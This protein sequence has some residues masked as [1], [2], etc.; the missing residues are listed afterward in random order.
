MATKRSATSADVEALKQALANT[1]AT[2]IGPSDEGFS[3]TIARWSKAAEKPA[4]VSVEPT[5]SEQVSIA[6]KY[7]TDNNLDLA[8]MG[9]GHSTAG[10]SSTDGGVLINLGRMRNVKVDVGEKQFHVEG[11]ALWSDVDAAGWEHGLATVGG[12]VAD[13]GVGGLT[14]GGGYGH[15]TGK[16]GLVID[17]VISITTVLAD[18]TI[19]KSSKDRHPEL[20]WGLLGAGQ[21][22]GVSTEFVFQAFPQDELWVG[23]MVFPAVP[24]IVKGLVN[25]LNELYQV[26][27]TPNGPEAKAKGRCGSLLALAKPPPAGGQ[28]MILLL[29]AFNGTEAEGK[30]VFKPFLDLGPVENTMAMQPYPKVN[31]LVPTI[32]GMRSSMKGAAYLMPV[33]PEFV[34]ELVSKYDEF[35]GQTPDAM[36]SLVA[37]EYYDATEMTKRDVGSFANRGYHLNGLVMPTWSSAEHDAKC[38]QWARDMSNMFKVELESQGQETGAGVEGAARRGKKGATMLYGN[39]DQY[40]EISKDVF[41]D[42]YERLQG[43]KAKYDPTNMFNKLF[44]ITPASVNG[45]KL[46]TEVGSIGL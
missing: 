36:A 45:V 43:I 8:V 38:R 9:G 44:P 46:K 22:F 41:G 10:A 31:A 21:N 11:G 18:G 25:S 19:V 27:E 5:N 23:M 6:V 7:A 30:E 37:F 40:D 33:R 3:Q 34:L 35:L 20:F 32:Q 29:S 1:N 12:T 14:L 26:R 16:Y 24:E 4:G 39:Y 17:N 42:N 15:L 13:T 28:T 2:V